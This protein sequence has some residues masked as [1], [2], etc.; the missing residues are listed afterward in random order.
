MISF[1]SDQMIDI[2]QTTKQLYKIYRMRIPDPTLNED[3]RRKMDVLSSIQS[4]LIDVE[5]IVPQM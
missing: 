2:D 5:E 1:L 4:R 3:Y